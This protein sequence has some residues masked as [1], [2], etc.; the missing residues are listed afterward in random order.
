MENVVE[1]GDLIAGRVNGRTAPDE[2][3]VFGGLRD[4]GMGT[5]FVATGAMLYKVARERG[6]G[7]EVPQD[8]FF[9]TVKSPFAG[10]D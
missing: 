3:T 7:R 9:A 4:G 8:W 2:I 5:Q 6:V 1:L 10:G